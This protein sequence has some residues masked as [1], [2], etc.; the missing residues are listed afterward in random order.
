MELL[1]LLVSNPGRLTSRRDLI[2]RVWGKDHHVEEDG[3]INTAV[4]KLRM[5]LDDS[6]EHPRFIETVTGRGYRFIAEVLTA[7]GPEPAAP[8]L[9]DRRTLIAVLPFENLSKSPGESYLSDGLTDELT[10]CLGALSSAHL[11]VVGRTTATE[12]HRRGMTVEQIGRELGAQFVVEGSVKGSPERVRINVRL[13]QVSD[14]AQVWARSYEKGIGD[15]LAWQWELAPEIAGE[16]RTAVPEGLLSGRDRTR[17]ADPQAYDRYLRGLHHWNK[18]SPLGCV[19]AIEQFKAAIEFDPTYP[20]PYAG[21]AN[22][23]I[24][25]GIHGVRAPQDTYPKA[26]A[27]AMKALE[28]DP[29]LAEAHAALGDVEKGFN[30]DWPSAEACFRKT[31]KLNSNYSLGHQWYANL[32]SIVGRHAEAV[33]EAEEA[34]DADPLSAPAAGF[35]ALTLYRARRFDEAL[36]QAE[37]AMDL[38]VSSPVVNWFVGLIHLHRRNYEAAREL[39]TRAVKESHDGAMFVATLAHVTGAAG[40]REGALELIRTLERRSGEQ[41]ISPLDMCVAHA[42]LGDRNAALLW[43]EKAVAERVMRV[44]ELEMPLYDLLRGEAGFAELLRRVGLP[45]HPLAQPNATTRPAV[46]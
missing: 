31:L 26:R 15:L 23:F 35:V 18:R 1:L 8:A 19:Q 5:A 13:V 44:T 27:A 2:D 41:Y 22:A 3:A 10:T 11:R 43:L 30:W 34:R 39:L 9:D 24:L 12:C 46:P 45:G 29:M 40:D 36:H 4:R 14:Q 6:A 17:R 32:L 7:N 28:I 38:N 37:K 33:H 42:G 16:M 25:L 21:M 20:L